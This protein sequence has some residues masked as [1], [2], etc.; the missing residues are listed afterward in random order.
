MNEILFLI[1]LIFLINFFLKEKNILLNNTG[2]IHQSYNQKYQVPLSGGLVILIYI[3]YNFELFKLTLIFYLTIFFILGLLADLNLIKSPIFRFLAQILLLIFFIVHLK[4]Q[5]Y[6]IRINWINNLLQYQF[7]NIFFVL[8]C[9]LVLING[10]NFIDGNNGISL[11]YY[12]IIFLLM[13]KLINDEIIIYN[14]NFFISFLITLFILLIFN[15]FNRLYIGDSGA[16]LLSVFSGYILIDIINQNQNLS[17][18]FIVNIF[19]YPAFEILFSLIRKIKYKYSPLKPDTKHLH[20]LLFFYYSKKI[21]LSKSFLNSITGISVNIFNGLILY[22]AS[23]NLNNTKIQLAF[24]LLNLTI[25]IT[26][27]FILYKFRNNQ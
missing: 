9:F 5:I 15:L 14:S 6:D 7:F 1:F 4:V 24:L 3:F 21:S 12:L 18:Y 10:T 22:F 26:I 27:Y 11:G 16:Y 23:M 20:Q 19:W 2:Q 8:F 17:P 25:Y 13:L